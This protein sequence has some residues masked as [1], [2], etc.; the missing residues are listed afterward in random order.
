MT[1][2]WSV[3]VIVSLHL[4]CVAISL[5]VNRH[6][7]LKSRK[8]P[9]LRQYML[10]QAMFLI[11][12]IAKVLKTLSPSVEL[13]WAFVVLQYAGS[14]FPGIMLFQ[15]AW[16][17]FR[18]KTLPFWVTALIWM[19]FLGFFGLV[20]TNPLHH[21]VYRTF[22]LQASS[23]GPV[24]RIHSYLTWG[25]MGLGIVLCI[26]AWFR[27][28]RRRNRIVVL[29]FSA[30]IAV[31][32][33][34]N[35]LYVTNLYPVVFGGKALFDYT[36][37]CAM[38]SLLLFAIAVFHWSMF[39]YGIFSIKDI[40][41]RIPHC[42]LLL[43]RKG[44]I[45]DMSRDPFTGDVFE[46]E[47]P[48]GRE[49]FQPFET[50]L[51]PLLVRCQTFMSESALSEDQELIQLGERTFHLTLSAYGTRNG[52]FDLC[53]A[54]LTDAENEKSRREV[55]STMRR[56][57]SALESRLNRM[58][59][60]QVEYKAFE[61]TNAF[62]RERL[63]RFEKDLSGLADW[64]EKEGAAAPMPG[65]SWRVRMKEGRTLLSAATAEAG[66]KPMQEDVR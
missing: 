51:A 65:R 4:L 3:F 9:V 46:W 37:I 29:L 5:G 54:I 34:F 20:A 44:Q 52:P 18:N 6:V 10:L 38:V 12:M 48:M 19:P 56:E 43:D 22:T 55:M 40:F 36:P 64:F 66:M 53:L 14:S 61:K 39:D 62:A 1:R 57:M 49:G 45:C 47:E 30:A 50:R 16:T 59:Q 63:N 58:R 31:P 26:F 24:F 41:S 2:P 8:T 27:D 13:R 35:A 32:L 15:F 21:L 25:L 33:A 42:V 60:A 17:Y 11:W 7:W 23:F 28:N